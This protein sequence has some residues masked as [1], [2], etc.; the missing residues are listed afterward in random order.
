MEVSERSAVCW[1]VARAVPLDSSFNSLVLFNGI[2]VP[3][4]TRNCKAG[5]SL[6]NLQP[7]FCVESAEDVQYPMDRRTGT[8]SNNVESV[9][10]GFRTMRCENFESLG[11]L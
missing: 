1:H 10:A 11:I 7:S 2:I 6:Y 3:R 8:S 9:V 4:F 5:R